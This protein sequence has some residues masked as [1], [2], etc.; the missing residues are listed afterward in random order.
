MNSKCSVS[1]VLALAGLGLSLFSVAASA[2]SLTL[3]QLR[4]AGELGFC[5]EVGYPP[6]EF[7]PE[8]SKDPEGFDIDLARELARRLGVKARFDNTGFDGIIAALLAKKCD[9]VISALSQTPAR[10]EQVNFVLYLQNNRALVVRKGNPRQVSR[11]DALCGLTVGAQIG[12]A[13]YDD[14]NK[15][16]DKCKSEGKPTL[17]VRSFKDASALKLALLTNQI[18]AYNTARWYIFCL[19]LSTPPS[20]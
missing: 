12:S 17:S 3:E 1:L 7:F 11:F 18:D 6:F 8:G 13:N 4:K 2:Q 20:C 5:T 9:V 16:S 15:L 10:Q 14:V 19:R